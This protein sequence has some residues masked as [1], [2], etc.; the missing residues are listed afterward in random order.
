[1]R[2]LRKILWPVSLVYALV[3]HI[4]NY[5]FD[6]GILRSRTFET[7]TICI[8]NL[9]VG[10]TGKTPMAELLIALLK[11][12]YKVALLSRGY[13]RDSTGFVMA[14]DRSTVAQLGDEPYQIHSKF[15]EITVAV[16]ADR[17][18]GIRTLED[19]ISPDVIV[20]DDAFQHRKVNYGLSILLTAYGNLYVDDTYLPTGNL[21]DTKREARRADLIVVT[22]CPPGLG[23]SERRAIEKQLH[24]ESHQQVLFSCL[25]YGTEVKGNI[26][27]GF[28][29][30]DAA[31]GNTDNTLRD[32]DVSLPDS[33]GRLQDKDGCP[34]VVGNIFQDAVKLPLNHFRDKKVTLVTGIANPQPLV[35]YLE[36]S[37]LAFE[38]LRFNDHHSFSEAD[39]GRLSEKEVLLTT[40]KDY[41]RLRGKV[42]NLYYLPVK[43]RF[44]DDSA[45]E[46]K[47]RLQ[48]LMKSGR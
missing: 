12:N 45:Q 15:P 26:G 46:L 23:R 41:V 21:R 27:G 39:V 4:R 16:D 33:D 31:H 25:E 6:V 17:G 3:V 2:L 34:G 11:E 42:D 37:G 7:P 8:G 35:V 36:A 24:P 43:H 48:E 44:L 32:G 29:D 10:G 1:M 18:N 30:S 40:E 9:S 5:L 22:K 47:A 28:E 19:G 14:S 20:L 13:R 38:H